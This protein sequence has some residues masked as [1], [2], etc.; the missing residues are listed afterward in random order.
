MGTLLKNIGKGLLYIIIAPLFIVTV[1]VIGVFGIFGLIFL[2]FKSIY[3][4]FTG[5]S[6]NDDL[7]ED[8]A[9][10]EVRN[11]RNPSEK[12][13]QEEIHIQENIV[14]EPIK[15]EPQPEVK[16]ATIEEAVFGE[17]IIEEEKPSDIQEGL[18][19]EE[20]KE[21]QIIEK[22]DDILSQFV[23]EPVEEPVEE[24][25]SHSIN[26]EPEQPHMT[27]IEMGPKEEIGIYSKSSN[28]LLDED[29]DEE[30]SAGVTISFGGH[31]DD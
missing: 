13:V 23:E 31:D 8:K 9:A 24:V 20:P 14:V 10:K 18:F 22:E 16:P 27:E 1:C 5:R 28:I 7:P 30:E 15:E 11:G 29:E 4:F 2:F 26:I 17:T 3:L 19:I 12:P 6:L 25:V 21:E